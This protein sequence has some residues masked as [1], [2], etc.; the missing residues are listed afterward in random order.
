MFRI[1]NTLLA[2]NNNNLLAGLFP[3]S[4][5]LKAKVRQ[6][7]VAGVLDSVCYG[8]ASPYSVPTVWSVAGP[9]FSEA[10]LPL[11][12]R[13]WPRLLSSQPHVPFSNEQPTNSKL[14]S[15]AGREKKQ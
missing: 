10:F 4:C 15:L 6:S 3:D 7:S 12:H 1:S 9:R 11:A 2:F 5:N 13:D 14:L 8:A